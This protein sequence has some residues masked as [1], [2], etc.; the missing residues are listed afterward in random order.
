[1]ERGQGCRLDCGK[2][3]PEQLWAI[4]LSREVDTQPAGHTLILPCPSICLPLHFQ[5]PNMEPSQPREQQKEPKEVGREQ[6]R[7]G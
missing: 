7:R 1:M 4:V 2:T 3:C 6:R 5:D